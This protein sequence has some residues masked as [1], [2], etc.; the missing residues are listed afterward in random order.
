[1]VF[2]GYK[3]MTFTKLKKRWALEHEFRKIRS[4]EVKRLLLEKGMPVFEKFGIRKVIL[5]GSVADNKY[6]EMSDLD[7]M[8]MPLSGDKYWDFHHEIEETLD[9]P[10]DLYTKYDHPVIVN[11]ILSRGEIVYEL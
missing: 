3:I 5:F 2:E 6:D 4:K 7:I 11:K 9:M 8:V 10:V 1:M